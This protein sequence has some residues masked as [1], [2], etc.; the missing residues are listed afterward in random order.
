M[1]DSFRYAHADVSK[2]LIKFQISPHIFR[3]LTKRDAFSLTHE[4]V[5]GH[6]GYEP[7]QTVFHIKD[8]HYHSFCYHNYRIMTVKTCQIRFLVF[9]VDIFRVEVA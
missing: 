7:F 3:N 2:T 1:V 5:S 6:K 8:T 4:P 9:F